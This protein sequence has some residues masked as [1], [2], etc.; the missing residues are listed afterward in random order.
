MSPF[1][2]E[3]AVRLRAC[4]GQENAISAPAL[5]EELGRPERHVRRVI[6]TDYKEIS[7]A[8]G[9]LLNSKPGAG[10]W[11]TTDA[12][13]IVLRHRRIQI[14]LEAYKHQETELK[15]VLKDFGLEGILELERRAA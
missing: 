1:A 5:A 7:R 4:I 9:G 15:A 3:I 12:D 2:F 11:V 14:G 6:S 8:A 10:F 13:E